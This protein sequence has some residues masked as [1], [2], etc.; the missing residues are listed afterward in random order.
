MVHYERVSDRYS[1]MCWTCIKPV[2]SLYLLFITN[3]PEQAT[4]TIKKFAPNLKN[5]QTNERRRRR[6][7]RKF[8]KNIQNE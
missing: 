6:S 5:E 8:L 4:W 1:I 2:Y 7:A 3:Q